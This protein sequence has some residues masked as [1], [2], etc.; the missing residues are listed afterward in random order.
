MSAVTERL[1]F[2]ERH[3]DI[4]FS[5]KTFIAAMAA[6]LIGFAADLP[7]PYWALAT[8]YITSQPLAGAT[9]SKALYRVIGTLV[10][11]A[12]SIVFV[13]ALVNSPEL[14][15]LTIAAWVGLCLYVSLLDR[16]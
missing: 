9:R 4:I 13:P 6:L 14:L 3:A 2:L 10:G 16:T 5:V 8:V 15:S 11:A 1:P 7:R 12:A